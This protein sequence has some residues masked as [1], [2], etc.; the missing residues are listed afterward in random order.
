MRQ[1]VQRPD[2]RRN[3]DGARSVTKHAETKVINL[4]DLGNAFSGG[5]NRLCFVHPGDPGR[6]IKVLRPDRSPAKKR[7]EQPFPKNLKPLSAFDENEQE[8]RVFRRIDRYIGD[9]AY[10]YIPHFY[11]LVKTNLGPGVCS[12][13]IRDED[14]GI[15]ITL[16][17]Y[18][19]THGRTTEIEQALDRFRAGWLALGM[20][21]RH[22]LL[23][24]IIVECRQQQPYRLVVIDGLGWP[25][26][27]LPYWVPPLARK[28]AAKRLN[29]LD[30][31]ISALL[32]KKTSG[33]DYGYH[34]W[35]TPEQRDR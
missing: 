3:Y 25:G 17:Q 33:E 6:C 4:G 19:W 5:G 21:S 11:G 18:L 16:K 2:V 8:I 27:P 23:H 1:N 10:A 13:L 22:L 15:S 30:L 28:K 35:L 26:L 32:K 14:G 34:G 29:R 12:E 7:R 31:A 24:N 9:A 20:P